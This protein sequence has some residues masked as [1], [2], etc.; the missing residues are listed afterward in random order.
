M[1]GMRL[2][3]LAFGAL[4]TNAARRLEEL[5]FKLLPELPTEPI[6]VQIVYVSPDGS[7][8]DGEKFTITNPGARFPRGKQRR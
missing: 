5:K 7:S 3:V 2:F 4:L 6:V 8:E 1:A